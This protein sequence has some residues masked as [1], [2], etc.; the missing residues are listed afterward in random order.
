MCGIFGY[1]GKDVSP[2]ALV[3]GIRRLEYR[4]YD[5]WGLSLSGEKGLALLRHVGKI[6]A[7]HTEELAREAALAVAGGRGGNGHGGNGVG[8]NGHGGNAVGGNG[9]GETASW[10]AGIAHTRWATHGVPSEANAH[11]HTDCTKSVA[12]IHNGIIENHAALRATLREKGHEFAS[13]TDTEVIPHL[14]EEFIREGMGV[15]AAFFAACKLLVGAYGI[16][17]LFAA[18]PGRLYV[19][20]HGSPIVLGLG[21]DASFV[22]S[23]PAPLVAYTRDVIYLDD[24]EA[25]ILDRD[26]FETCTLDG[27]PVG[28]EVQQIAFSLPQIERGGYEHFMLKEIAEQPESIRNAFRGRIA[29]SEGTAKLGGVE[30]KLLRRIKRCH[31]IACGTSWHAGMIG[32]LMLEDLARLPTQ[33]SISAEFRYSRPV[34]EPDTLVIAISQSG[35]TADTLGAV[36]EAKRQGA[37]AIGICNS[38]GSTIARECGKGIYIHAGPEIGVASTKAFTSQLIVLGLLA[39]CLGR[40]RGMGLRAGI[41]YLDALERLPEQAAALLAHADE[42]QEAARAYAACEDFLYVGRLY[43]YPTALEGALKLKEI[44][45]IHAEGVEAAELKHGPIALVEPKVPTV[46]LA[47]QTGIR[48]KTL[49]N[50]HEILARGG[51]LIAVAREGDRE[52]AALAERTFFIPQT[53]DPLVPVLSVIPLQLFAYY[54]AVARGCDV[55]KPRNLAKSVTVE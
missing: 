33:V 26:G 30:E 2:E 43:E 37:E 50:A 25:A 20:R 9:H 15:S 22:A 3:E 7:A 46:L 48:D 1:V 16:A 40:M 34:L 11:P 27:V 39:V 13:E 51:K 4:G 14:I 28:K 23:D 18:E 36:R 42:Y 17:A 49:G 38:V 10:Q 24:G 6:G 35:E 41:E 19:A 54:I 21:K 5:S 29:R 52:V 44:S 55:D 8:G 12:V 53:P 45:Y 47:A 32:K 31:I